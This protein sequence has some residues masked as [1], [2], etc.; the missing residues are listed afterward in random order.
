MSTTGIGSL[1]LLSS[2]VVQL[3]PSQT[4]NGEPKTWNSERLEFWI[5]IRATQS[6]NEAREEEAFS[7]PA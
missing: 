6:L 3:T 2:N 5:A 4:E 1:L 7:L